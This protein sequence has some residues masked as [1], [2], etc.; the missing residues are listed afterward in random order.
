MCQHH[1]KGQLAPSIMLLPLLMLLCMTGSHQ[2]HRSGENEFLFLFAFPTGNVSL[3]FNVFFL[4]LYMIKGYQYSGHEIA[5]FWPT[6]KRS[7][8]LRC[9]RLRSTLGKAKFHMTVFGICLL[10]EIGSMITL[11][12]AFLLAAG[13]VTA[14]IKSLTTFWFF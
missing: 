4:Q 2:G 1:P 8:R 14:L 11:T 10:R 3:T 9:Q 5:N 13:L 6:S 12:R 7:D